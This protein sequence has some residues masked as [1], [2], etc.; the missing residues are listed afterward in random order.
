MEDVKK[1]TPKYYIYLIDKWYKESRKLPINQWSIFQ[2][3]RRWMW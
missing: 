3:A 2:R 1:I